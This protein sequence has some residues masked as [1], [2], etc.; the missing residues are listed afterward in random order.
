MNMGFC[1]LCCLAYRYS[2]AFPPTDEYFFAKMRN[3]KIL[4]VFIYFVIIIPHWIFSLFASVD[5]MILREKLK[6][7]VTLFANFKGPV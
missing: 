5:P 2:V 7:E 4:L 6:Q 3:I 1:L